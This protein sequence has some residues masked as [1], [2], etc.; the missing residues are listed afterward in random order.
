MSEF[1]AK[2]FF[3]DDE[4]NPERF[5]DYYEEAAEECAERPN[6]VH[7]A[8]LSALSRMPY[9]DST[10]L[11]EDFYEKR[12][13]KFKGDLSDWA[14]QTAL[15]IDKNVFTGYEFGADLNEEAKKEA[16]QQTQQMMDQMGIADMT[17]DELY[18]YMP[19]DFKRDM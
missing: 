16:E 6:P 7:E 13:E 2:E 18:Q 10:G 3:R 17:E 15:D 12:G 8:E 5:N 19:G 1:N 9:E 4:D 14:Y 11:Y